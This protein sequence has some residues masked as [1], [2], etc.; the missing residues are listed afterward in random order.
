MATFPLLA[1][2]AIIQFPAT[3]TAAMSTEIIQFVDGSEQRFRN[4]SAPYHTWIIRL[5]ALDEAEM[6]Q[7]RNFIVQ[8]NGGSGTFSFT[9]PWDSS[10][11]ASCSFQ[12]NDFL[13]S[14]S[15]PFSAG[16]TLTIRENRS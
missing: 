12:G 3:R 4:Y 11:Y 7:L 14:L 8:T 1:T 5:A 9:D 16:V 2:G 6:Q 10:V 15:A 13:D